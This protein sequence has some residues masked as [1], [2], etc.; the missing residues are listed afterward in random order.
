M[1]LYEQKRKTPSSFRALT[2]LSIAQFGSHA[3]LVMGRERVA[4]S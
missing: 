3:G 2:G 1:T 4:L